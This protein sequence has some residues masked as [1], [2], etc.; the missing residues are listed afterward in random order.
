ME[1]RGAWLDALNQKTVNLAAAQRERGGSGKPI[2]KQVIDSSR[3]FGV[4]SSKGGTSV[5][6]T[7][8]RL[9]IAGLDER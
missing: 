3:A 1:G 7:S 8:S 5:D 6:L 2:Q 9:F 4:K